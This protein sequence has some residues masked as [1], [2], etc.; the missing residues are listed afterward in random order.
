M[1][2]KEGN[3]KEALSIYKEASQN[4]KFYNNILAGNINRCINKL[5]RETFNSNEVIKYNANHK[6]KNWI[7]EDGDVVLFITH[8][9]SFT[10]APLVLIKIINWLVEFRGITPIILVG[11]IHTALIDKFKKF[12]KLLHMPE[13]NKNST[14]E[15]KLFID[16]LN[17]KFVYTNTVVSGK[18]LQAVKGIIKSDAMYVTH[19]HEKESV[20]SQYEAEEKYIC[21]HSSKIVTVSKSIMKRLDNLSSMGVVLTEIPPFIERYNK[22]VQNEISEMPTIWGCGTIEDR[23]GFD[24]FCETIA[25]LKKYE[26][27][28]FKAAWIGTVQSNKFVDEILDKYSARQ[29]VNLI[30]FHPNPRSLYTK[31]DIFFLSSKEEPFSLASIEA[32]EQSLALLTFDKRCSPAMDEFVSE[33]GCGLVAK[34]F[35]TND[36]SECL[37]LMLEHPDMSERMG[38]LGRAAVL[39]RYTTEKVMPKL[40]EFIEQPLV[41]KLSN[42]KRNKILIISLG[43]VP[44]SGLKIMEGGGLRNWGL[45]RGFASLHEN[46]EV[47]LTFPSWFHNISNLGEFSGVNVITWKDENELLEQVGDFDIVIASYCFGGLSRAIANKISNNQTLIF[48]CYVPIHPEVCA[49]NSKDRIS[50][51]LNYQ[52]DKKIWNDVI[53]K[54]DFLLCASEQQKNYYFGLLFGLGKINPI[55]YDTSDNL[56]VAPFGL[57]GGDVPK[58]KNKPITK[59]LKNNS[60]KILWFGGVYPWFDLEII[61]GALKIIRISVKNI[62]LVIVGA[63]NPFNNHPDFLDASNRVIDLAQSSEYS[64]FVHLADWVPYEDRYDWYLDSDLMVCFNRD[65]IENRFAWRT[66][67]LDYLQCEVKFVT[68]GGDPISDLLIES[69]LAHKVNFNS[70]YE[71]ANQLLKIIK[72]TLKS[73]LNTIK[74]S[75]EINGA[76][77]FKIIKD[78]LTW[79][80]I[81]SN[82]YKEIF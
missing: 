20:L 9:A 24:L 57:D 73:D 23:K 27:L 29:H 55:N 1:Y 67:L 44:V 75:N 45:A 2:Y 49:R 5:A 33:I 50:E 59:I 65:G 41:F 36:A 35:N 42:F 56:I 72:L 71:L 66:R 10:G 81:C 63:K 15:L 18:Y 4:S 28:S 14:Q 31:G 69:G 3:F 53:L 21:Q 26:H 74:K 62:E 34:A 16:D 46:L 64:E 48:D 19:I 6:D 37:K 39:D 17:I 70:D 30:G 11:G 60:Y 13:I 79:T 78:Q 8:E 40:L 58:V 12:G 77:D 68:N 52:N 43:P 61:L 32:A 80:N 22:I 51:F 38:A 54:A 82:I 47:V 7:I 25:K 76:V